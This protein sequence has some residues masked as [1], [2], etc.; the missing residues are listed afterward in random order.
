MFTW[1]Y[2]QP[3]VFYLTFATDFMIL[4]WVLNFIYRSAPLKGANNTT[5][6]ENYGSGSMETSR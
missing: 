1:V 5:A 3:S 6:S 4:F 2:I